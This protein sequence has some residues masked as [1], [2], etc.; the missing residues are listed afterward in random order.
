MVQRLPA[1]GIFCSI[2]AHRQGCLLRMSCL[3]ACIG[4][5]EQVTNLSLDHVPI[6]CSVIMLSCH[7]MTYGFHHWMNLVVIIII[8]ATYQYVFEFVRFTFKNF[9]NLGNVQLNLMFFFTHR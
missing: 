4:S 9:E 3:G 6:V 7:Y 2:T 5:Y 1:V 8:I